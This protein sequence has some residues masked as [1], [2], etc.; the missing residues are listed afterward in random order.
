MSSALHLSIPASSITTPD[1]GKPYTVYHITLQLPLRKLEVK[2]RYND[3]VQ[4]NEKLTSQTDQ[5]PPIQLPPKSWIRRTINSDALTEERRTGLERYLKG[6]LEAEDARWRS[7]KAWKDFLGIAATIGAAK[8]QQHNG[9]VNDPYEWLDVH[10]TL[11]TKINL[12]RQLLSQRD[13][14]MT[15]QQQHSLSIDAKASLVR[16]ATLV[17]QLS[18]GL[19]SSSNPNRDSA[20]SRRLGE[21]EIRRRRDLLSAAKKE[22]EGLESLLKSNPTK[23]YSSASGSGAAATSTDKTVLL[24]GTGPKP[25]GRVL[26]GP[27]KET[28]R[29]RELDNAGIL[30]LQQTIMQE[31]EEDV[32]TLGQ[33]VAKLKDMGLMINEELTIQNEMLSLLDN[34]VDRVQGKVDTA[35][36]RIKKIS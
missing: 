18:D 7:S 31:Q 8:E 2:K 13:S 27:L 21:G 3:F 6:I 26:G 32:L 11:K 17:A 16:A 19:S 20:G 28:N 10:R 36:K 15:A 33:T 25:L 4:L 30:Q 14:A 29:T 34:D 5:P 23:V 24:Q 35:R 22:I 9:G 12:A 1:S